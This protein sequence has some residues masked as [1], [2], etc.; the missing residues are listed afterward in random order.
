MQLRRARLD[1]RESQFSYRRSLLAFSGRREGPNVPRVGRLPLTVRKILPRTLLAVLAI[2]VPQAAHTAFSQLAAPPATKLSAE[3]SRGKGVFLQRCSL[4]HL[5]QLPG[6]RD[7]FGPLLTGV[8]KDASQ[9]QLSRVKEKILKGSAAMPGFQYGL[10]A[11]EVD[12]L[13]AFVRTL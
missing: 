9:A 4:C 1:R 10:D 3:Q 13:L 7:P 2:V 5:P 8:L 11:R 12:D 6:R